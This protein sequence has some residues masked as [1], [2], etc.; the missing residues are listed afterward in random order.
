[1][2]LVMAVQ[3]AAILTEYELYRATGNGAARAL[4]IA[5]SHAGA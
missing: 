5:A 2:R 3:T 4:A 1:M